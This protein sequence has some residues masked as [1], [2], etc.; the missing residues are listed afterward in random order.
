MENKVNTIELLYE[1]S[2]A[3]IARGV[4][5]WLQKEDIAI[6]NKEPLSLSSGFCCESFQAIRGIAGDCAVIFISDTATGNQDWQDQVR[7]LPSGMRLIPV[8]RLKDVDYNYPNFL[9]HCI[10][11]INFIVMN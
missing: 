10:V 11:D 8:G 4:S 9:P 3:G 5:D 2:C 6:Q 7:A 1:Q